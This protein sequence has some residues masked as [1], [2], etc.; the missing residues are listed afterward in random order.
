M[1]KARPPSEGSSINEANCSFPA[2][3]HIGSTLDHLVNNGLLQR[4]AYVRFFT[5]LVTKTEEVAARNGDAVEASHALQAIA[6]HPEV[7]ELI[8]KLPEDGPGAII[9]RANHLLSFQKAHSQSA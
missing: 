9:L 5:E 2:V 3:I 4:D 8:E 6:E 7:H 1:A